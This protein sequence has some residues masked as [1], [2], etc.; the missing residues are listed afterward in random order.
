LN[1]LA[2]V[3]FISRALAGID[4]LV[5]ARA[6]W[7]RLRIPLVL[8]SLAAGFLA[9]G[10]LIGF[11]SIDVS[12][13][14]WL[15]GDNADAYLGAA[16][17]G[18]DPV[19][20]FPL[21]QTAKLGFP[22]G[23][24]VAYLDAI[25]IVAVVFKAFQPLLPDPFQY[26]G[27]YTLL[28]IALQGYFG[29]ALGHRLSGGNVLYTLLSGVM[30]MLTPALTLRLGGHIALSSH[31]LILAAL[32]EHLRLTRT[33]NRSLLG[34]YGVLAL[35]GGIN[36]YFSLMC[37]ILFAATLLQLVLARRVSLVG[38]LLA[39]SAGV[40]LT[41]A[42][43]VIFGFIVSASANSYSGGG[44]GF[45]SFNLS[46]PINPAPW[47]SMILPSWPLARSGQYEGFN[48]LGVGVM[49]LAIVGIVCL[50]L[51]ST[52]LL[53]QHIPL[54][55]ACLL[56]TA[57]AASNVLTFGPFELVTVPLPARVVDLLSAYR[58]SGR[59]F[60]PVVYVITIFG[61]AACYRVLGRRVAIVVLA[62]CVCLQYFDSASVRAHVVNFSRQQVSSPFTSDAWRTLGRDHEALVV[63]PSWQCHSPDRPT[64]GGQEQGHWYFG[65][66]AIEQKLALNSYYSGRSSPAESVRHCLDLPQM[67]ASGELT[68]K[69]AYVLDDIALASFESNS[70]RCSK[71]DGVNLCR[72]TAETTS[73]QPPRQIDP[74]LGLPVE[75]TGRPVSIGDI[76]PP[77]LGF[78]AGW[79]AI[80]PGLGAWTS[81]RNARL[82]LA[83]AGHG[84]PVRVDM[85]AR[86][87]LVDGENNYRILQGATSVKEGRVSGTGPLTSFDTSFTVV[88]DAAG[89]VMLTIQADKVRTPS[90]LGINAD[91]RPL[92]LLLERIS[93]HP[94][95]NN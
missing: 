87:I 88:P 31:W 82:A 11:R 1:S 12:S 95:Q 52:R 92:G 41:G 26:C 40:A 35:A 19:W 79:H 71:I 38:A 42:M 22:F 56:L 15:K 72:V 66:I 90:S 17:L 30:F 48:Y 62:L 14:D 89:V 65:R 16:F 27:L 46:S 6:D 55:L 64:P 67:I 85:H 70:H 7:Q 58:A 34:Y 51:R 32:N 24:S 57:L 28:C 20:H 49:T 23:V 33:D 29:A 59:L 10:L 94:V 74:S 39:G 21:S 9:T 60:W 8:M 63:I 53:V 75:A 83:V 86:S 36:P 73:P 3:S 77:G 81:H 43:L 37:L 80:E 47:A 78:L 45:Y 44:Y 68:P 13:L 84:G 93:I 54:I 25:P 76:K 18:L 50:G 5:A 69:T 2:S 91:R 61:L 4:Q